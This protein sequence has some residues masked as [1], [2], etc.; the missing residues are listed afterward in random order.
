MS[1]KTGYRRGVK[2]YGRRG[3]AVPIDSMDSWATSPLRDALQRRRWEL[4]LSLAE[5]AT[6]S[7]VATSTLWRHEQGDRAPTT[8]QLASWAK[9]LGLEEGLVNYQVEAAQ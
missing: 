1:S 7:G 5:V 9:A 8:E 3:K 6:L 4:R 2:R